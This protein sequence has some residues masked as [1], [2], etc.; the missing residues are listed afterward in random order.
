M[1][2][3]LAFFGCSDNKTGIAVTY[4]YIYKLLLLRISYAYIIFVNTFAC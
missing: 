2:L 1:L 4:I 3:S